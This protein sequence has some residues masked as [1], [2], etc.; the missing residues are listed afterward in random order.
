MGQPGTLVPLEDLIKAQHPKEY[1]AEFI[2]EP[3]KEE[4]EP[5]CCGNCDCQTTN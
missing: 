4:T 2:D 3:E 1:K 5:A